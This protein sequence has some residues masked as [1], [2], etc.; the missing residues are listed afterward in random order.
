MTEITITEGLKKLKLIE[1]RM[2]KNCA[3]IVKYSSLLSNEKPIF[4][5]EIK[6]RD[7]VNKLIQSNNDLEKEYCKIKS[8]I[9]YTNLIVFVQ[10]D[11]E[12]RSIHDWLILLRK[13]GKS[14]IS[15]YESLTDKEAL[16]RS[17]VRLRDKDTPIPTNR[18]FKIV[19]VWIR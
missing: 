13:T 12:K 4:E 15:T 14:I 18:P 8:M 19:N 7:E 2:Q 17:N 5:T 3:E 9:D 1:K 11:N 6:Q 16:N 10:I